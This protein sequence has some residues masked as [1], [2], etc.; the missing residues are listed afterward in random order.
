MTLWRR[1]DVQKLKTVA[2]LFWEIQ[3]KKMDNLMF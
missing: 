2:I 1:N 3:C